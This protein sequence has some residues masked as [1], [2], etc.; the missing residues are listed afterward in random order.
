VSKYVFT[1]YIAGQASKSQR[2][3]ANLRHACESAGSPYELTIV[4]ILESPDA[5]EKAKILAIPTLVRES[6]P[7]AKRVIGDLSNHDA[8]INELDIRSA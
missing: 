8:L 3:V 4:D 6:P 1:L 5:A 7:P 2:A